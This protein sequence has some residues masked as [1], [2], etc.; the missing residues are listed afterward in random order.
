MHT[1]P[2]SRRSSPRSTLASRPPRK[3]PAYHHQRRPRRAPHLVV[4]VDHVPQTERH[5]DDDQAFP[6]RTSRRAAG[7]GASQRGWRRGSGR[8]PRRHHRAALPVRQHAARGRRR[9]LARVASWPWL[10][11]GP[12]PVCPVMRVDIRGVE[13]CAPVECPF[14][15]GKIA[16]RPDGSIRNHAGR[17][18]NRCPGST[19]HD[20]AI[21]AR[22]EAP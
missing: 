16:T 10:P 17:G 3:C 19:S 21:R 4:H 2:S 8:L 13:I 22:K 6:T 11:P 14:C 7:S 15:L 18:G 12:G 9:T 20:S 1:S 5:R